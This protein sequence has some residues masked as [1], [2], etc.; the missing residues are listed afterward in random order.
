MSLLMT[1]TDLLTYI[2]KQRGSN[3]YNYYSYYYWPIYTYCALIHPQKTD[4]TM[5]RKDINLWTC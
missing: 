5:Y 2:M 4:L 1:Y 3:D